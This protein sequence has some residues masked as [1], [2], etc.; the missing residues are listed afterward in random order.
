MREEKAIQLF[1]ILCQ[2]SK[3]KQPCEI[4][5]VTGEPGGS[6]AGE[7]FPASHKALCEVCCWEND[8]KGGNA[9][10]VFSICFVF[11]F[12]RVKKCRKNSLATSDPHRREIRRLLAL[13]R[14]V[15]DE[16]TRGK[17]GVYKL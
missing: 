11:S 4:F 3:N 5:C 14:C 6:Q 16:E 13:L 12:S 1:N 8:E 17:A 2:A 15:G 9:L 10:R 7:D